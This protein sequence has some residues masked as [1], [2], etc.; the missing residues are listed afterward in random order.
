[1]E[2]RLE[3]EV[4]KKRGKIVHALLTWGSDN[5]RDFPW[6]KNSTP[7]NILIAEI[8]LRRTTAKAACRI[9][10]DFIK[11]YPD[12][13]A[14]ANADIK[15]LERILSAVGYHKRRAAILKEVA[16]FITS[17]YGGTIPNKKEE[18][19]R[20]PHVGYYTAGAILSLGYGIPSAMVDSN[21]ERII[22]RVFKDA[23]PVNGVKLTV[24]KIADMMVPEDG[25]KLFNL[26][27][28]DIGALICRYSK[29]SCHDCPLQEVCDTAL[30]KSTSR[31]CVE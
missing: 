17:V 15:D 3:K 5:A 1:M 12:I 7:Y 22:R 16:Q 24:I 11:H 23:M 31:R 18:L 8:I 4:G 19:L 26:A 21:V 28:L 20:I 29:T 2:P 9:Y 10:G 6:R 30:S 25:H 27:L 14:L 13:K